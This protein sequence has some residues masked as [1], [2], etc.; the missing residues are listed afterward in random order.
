M[1]FIDKIVKIQSPINVIQINQKYNKIC[2]NNQKINE[3]NKTFLAHIL[4][5]FNQE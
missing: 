3:I 4:S 5:I 2:V 1:E